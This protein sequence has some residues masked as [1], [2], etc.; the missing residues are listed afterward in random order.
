MGDDIASKNEQYWIT[1]TDFSSNCIM[2]LGGNNPDVFLL[3]QTDAP[4]CM[5]ARKRGI[6]FDFVRG[7]NS[8]FILDI[9]RMVCIY[10]F[11]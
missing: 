3:L 6:T 2:R 4:D 7:I 1:S 9:S 11:Y 5:K 10:L 8:I